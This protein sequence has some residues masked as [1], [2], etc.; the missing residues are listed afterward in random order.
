MRGDILSIESDSQQ[1]GE[2]LITQVMRGDILSI[3]SD[4]QQPGETLITQVMRGGKRVG[5]A[6]TLA[7]IRARA[8][9]DLARLPAALAQ[10]KPGEGYPVEVADALKALAKEADTATK[11]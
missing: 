9:T 5:A 7:D 1:P 8:K 10:L 6:P 3:E 11:R 2:T 4:S